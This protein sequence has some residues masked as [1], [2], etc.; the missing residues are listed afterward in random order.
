VEDVEK[1]ALGFALPERRSAFL[2][3]KWTSYTALAQLEIERGRPDVAFAFSERLRGRAMMELLT[4][5]RVD[6]ASDDAD[7]AAREQ[8][9]RRRIRE[10]TRELDVGQSSRTHLR[11]PGVSRANNQKR[12]QLLAA[13]SRY[14]DLLLDI[15]ERAPRHAALIAHE[16]VSWRQIAAR[17][18]AGQA[19]VEYLVG[20]SASFA[21]I[22]RQD[23]IAA[24][25]L[26]VA[27]AELRRLV[28][29][30]RGILE[31]RPVRRSRAE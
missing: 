30:A 10:L 27:R 8:D 6:A 16:P 7:L 22:V 24:V 12:E 13:E 28:T 2:A 15:R 23:T 5:G 11:G 17:L 26:H 1:M 31:S 29:F 14:A 21:F 9:A 4:R 20:D 18:S 25:E 3:N 19:L